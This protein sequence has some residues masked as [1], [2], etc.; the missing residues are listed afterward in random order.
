MIKYGYL[1][2]ELYDHH[3]AYITQLQSILD[4]QSDQEEWSAREIER[5]RDERNQA[6]MAHGHELQKLEQKLE[7]AHQDR[8][9]ALRKLTAGLFISRTLLP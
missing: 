5:L 2:S 3:V 6:T 4:R 8:D 1:T 7:Q 9:A